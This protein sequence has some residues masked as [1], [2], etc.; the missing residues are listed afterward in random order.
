M[1]GGTLMGP[2]TYFYI[3]TCTEQSFKVTSKMWFHF[4]P[5]GIDFL[6]QLPFYTLSGKDKL[7]YFYNFF[8]ESTFQQSQ[9]LTLAKIVSWM[10]YTIVSI[11]IIQKYRKQLV[12]KVS[13]IDA[14]FHRWLFLFCIALLLPTITALFYVFADA[15]FSFAFLLGS[16]FLTILTAFSLL[17]IKPSLFSCSPHQ[18]VTD[19]PVEIIKQKYENSN[20][21]ADQ[22]EKYLEKLITFVEREKIYQSV[23]LTLAELADKVNI[24]AHYVSQIINEKLGVNFLDFINGYRVKAAQEMLTDSKWSHYTII[25]IAY[26]AGFNAKSTFYAVFKKQAGMTP[27]AYRKQVKQIA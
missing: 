14:A 27:S 12:D 25:A 18:I 4:I 20:L 3:R 21:Q 19:E 2:M 13:S 26:E 5:F 15:D 17:I 6:F 23:E 7:Q 22:K 10:I 1:L 11:R 9:W 8:I 24:P 16:V